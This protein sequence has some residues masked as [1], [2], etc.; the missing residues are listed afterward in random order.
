MQQ[1]SWEMY[2]DEG[3]L[4]VARMMAEIKNA[5]SNQSLPK[6]R[7]LIHQKIE[8]ISKKHGEIYDSEVRYLIAVRLTHWASEAHDLKSV[9][10][11]NSNYW[12]L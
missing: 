7:Q 1:E 10:G 3:N 6:I 11:F 8:E 2:D 5:I 4:A 12:G 9:F